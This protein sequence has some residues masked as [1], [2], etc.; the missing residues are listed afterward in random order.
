MSTR[1]GEKKI[2]KIQN[3]Y[4][5]KF[6]V[7]NKL[8]KHLKNNEN[9]EKLKIKRNKNLKSQLWKQILVTNNM[10]FPGFDSER[11]AN[12]S[13]H[14]LISKTFFRIWFSLTSYHFRFQRP[15]LTNF[16]LLKKSHFHYLRGNFFYPLKRMVADKKCLSIIFR[17]TTNVQFH[18]NRPSRT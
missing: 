6:S 2:L 8:Y 1:S 16:W 4:F 7:T 10:V 3:Y 15:I 5:W 14:K 9:L 18:S 11:N 13:A 17:S 12:K